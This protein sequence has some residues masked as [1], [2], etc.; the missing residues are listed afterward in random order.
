MATRRLSTFDDWVDYFQVWLKDIDLDP[1]ATAGYKFEAKYGELHSPEIE[2]G[3][4]RGD[5]KWEK[6]LDVPDQRIR[7][8]LLHLIT[9]Q[10]DTEFASVE[11]QR[12]LFAT[13]P[14][15]HDCQSLVRIMREEIRHG[16]QMCHILMTH[17]GDSG[18]IE[19][20]KLL[21]RRSFNN[22]RLLGSFNEPV[23]NWL[24][25]FTYT[26]FIDRDGKFQL[27]MLSHS[28]F[29]PLAR[30]MGPM[31]K[32][33][34]FHL[35]TGNNGL[36]RII[37]AGRLPLPIVQKYFNK[38]IPTAY[39][40]FGSSHSSSAHWSYV[41]GLKG[42]FDEDQNTETPD[43]DLLNEYARELY[44]VEIKGLVDLLNR[45]RPAGTPALYVPDIRH[46]RNI[47]EFAGQRYSV[48]GRLLDEAAYE[49]HLA[50]TLPSEEDRSTI[51]DFCRQEGWI[52]SR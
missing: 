9:Y 48:D 26:Q 34:S 19:A 24:D 3:D 37:K 51:A 21:E 47:G 8:A 40:L 50:E 18:K 10:G 31:L 32:E 41:W 2:F 14:S 42:R 7:D 4:Y 13:A 5:R 46:H 16:W 23:E 33:E 25:F 45:E 15:D 28:A 43:R 49:R 20:Q 11:Q 12:H 22:N 44:H 39:D 29:A 27:G 38:W 1:S 6:I 52:L 35:G 17:F 36:K 30:S